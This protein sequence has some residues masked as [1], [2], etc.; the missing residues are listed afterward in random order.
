MFQGIPN[1]SLPKPFSFCCSS[2]FSFIIQKNY[3][4][5]YYS[6]VIFSNLFIYL[7]LKKKVNLFV[8][9]VITIM[10]LKIPAQFRVFPY[11]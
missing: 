9:I 11:C 10:A 4:Y 5:Y 6:F 1:L 7:F 8:K 3:Y 2:V